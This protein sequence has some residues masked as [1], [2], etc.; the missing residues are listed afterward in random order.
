MSK[1]Q[2]DYYPEAATRELFVGNLSKGAEVIFKELDGFSYFQPDR[3]GR[4]Y[5]FIGFKSAEQCNAAL[6][7][8]TGKM[9]KKRII[10][11][12]RPNSYVPPK[13][14]KQTKKMQQKLATE[15]WEE[16]ETVLANYEKAQK[17]YIEQSEAL[18]Y[19][20]EQKKLLQER[21]QKEKDQKI[22]ELQQ[23]LEYYKKRDQEILAKER[24]LEQK[25]LFEQQRLEQ[26]RL[27]EQQQ[28][29]EQQRLFEQ[30]R[31]EQQQRIEQQLL[32]ERQQQEQIEKQKLI[33]QLH[34]FNFEVVS[35]EQYSLIQEVQFGPE[36]EAE[37]S[38]YFGLKD[39]KS[40]SGLQ[41]GSTAEILYNALYYKY[42]HY[43]LLG[44]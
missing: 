27:F 29:L 8:L 24:E 33:E 32:I 30:Q 4:P 44:I 25:R 34:K 16:E 37:K 5:G 26:Q 7:E 9:F 12:R 20:E 13:I 11:V 39:M 31:L 28:L 18:K 21:E 15:K 1:P 36:T 10:E 2:K 14:T 42:R 43:N 38:V 3:E 41:P 35:A 22:L 40:I 19:F 6:E 23:Q 17:E